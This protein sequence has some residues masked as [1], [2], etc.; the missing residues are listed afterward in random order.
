MARIGSSGT[1]SAGLTPVIPELTSDP[2]SPYA[3]ETWVLKKYTGTPIG[4]LLSLT[5]LT[6]IYFLSY[7]TT[8]GTIV[9]VQLQ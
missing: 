6:P 8:E 7:Y 9:R 1:G 3:G 2:A 5:Q 4:L